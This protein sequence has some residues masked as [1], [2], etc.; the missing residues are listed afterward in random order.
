MKN[1]I[2]VSLSF[3]LLIFISCAQKENSNA[4]YP[5]ADMLFGEDF[6][7]IKGKKVGVVTN[8]SGLLRNGV[9]L[10]DTLYGCKD[11]ILTALFAPEHGVRGDAPDGDAISN[12]IDPKT[13]VPIYSIYMVNDNKPTKENLKDIDVLIYDIQEVGVRFYTYI[14]TLFYLLETGAE[15]GIPIIVL[16]RPNP[17]TGLKVDGPIRKQEWFSF[18]GIAPIPIMHGMTIGELAILFNESGMLPNNLKA[19]LTVVKMKNWTRNLYYDQTGLKWVN[20]SPNISSLEIAVVYPGTCLV[21]GL[22]VSEGRGT[23]EPFLTIGAPYIEPDK[24]ISELKSIQ[25][26]GIDYLPLYSYT[27]VKIPNTARAPKYENTEIKGIKLKVTNRLEFEPVEF[28]VKL[29]CAMYK[30][31]PDDLRIEEARFNRLSGDSRIRKMILSGAK[32]EEIYAIWQEELEEFKELR[33]KYLLY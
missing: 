25:I 6:H 27:P 18:V 5:G 10:V 33:K 14:S 32:A 9:H 19:D 12:A 2:L 23:P 20:P 30:L 13:G 21:E 1:I 26:K 4:V 28:G 29:I 15:N 11:V 7:L 3:V 17:I 8:H 16:D 24:L 22:N 31:F